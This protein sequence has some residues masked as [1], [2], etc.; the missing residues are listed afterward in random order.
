MN[1]LWSLKEVTKLVY[2]DV[3]PQALHK[4]MKADAFEPEVYVGSSTGPGK[5]NMLSLSD[6]VVVGILRALFA[7]GLGTKDLSKV[8]GVGLW[9]EEMSEPD[10]LEID[11]AGR[12]K[13][14][15]YLELLN[16][17]ATVYYET[18][19]IAGPYAG[20]FWQ[21]KDDKPAKEELSFIVFPQRSAS[22]L[23]WLKDRG[24]ATISLIDVSQWRDYVVARLR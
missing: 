18:S 24:A 10:K 22:A 3:T 19:S 11:K 21:F 7:L 15:R 4:W 9:T 14:Q 16:Y 17:A 8:G 12:R 20:G 1:R 23:K 6:V 2:T 13:L 5:G